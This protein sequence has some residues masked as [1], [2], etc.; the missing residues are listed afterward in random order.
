MAGAYFLKHSKITSSLCDI[1]ES[2]IKKLLFK[3]FEMEE[4]VDIADLIKKDPTSS[5][6]YV[7]SPDV[8]KLEEFD[9]VEKHFS[10]YVSLY[11]K[12]VDI[13]IQPDSFFRSYRS[14]IDL[15]NFKDTKNTLQFWKDYIRQLF[16]QL[17]SNEQTKLW[18][19]LQDMLNYHSNRS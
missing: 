13:E 2:T 18:N 11:K 5:I 3:P 9:D 15:Q 7:K 17:P 19:T 8:Y 14:I 4:E 16:D 12:H 6:S 10:K 1:K